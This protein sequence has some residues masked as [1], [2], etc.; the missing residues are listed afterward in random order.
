PDDMTIKWYFNDGSGY[1]EYNDPIN[2]TDSIWIEYIA[3]T[4]KYVFASSGS[5]NVTLEV[6]NNLNFCTTQH[7]E[8]FYVKNP[9]TFLTSSSLNQ[10]I[11]Q[12]EL[13]QFVVSS[14]TSVAEFQFYVNNNPVGPLS[15]NNVFET[16][17]I[18]DG[19]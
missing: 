9:S 12:G 1:F 8:L 17:N 5:F 7:S 10:E 2:P 4:N 13:V 15:S 16:T 11:C 6:T 14:D 19:D 3:D 18:N